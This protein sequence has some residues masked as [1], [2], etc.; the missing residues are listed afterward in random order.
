MKKLFKILL[1]LAIVVAAVAGIYAWASAGK[2]DDKNKLVEVK[3]GS[4]TEKAL[5]VGQIEPRQ[6]FSVKSKISGVVKKCL[7]QVGDHVRPG[8]PLFEIAPA[9]T[10]TD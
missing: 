2:K 5:A 8:D 6:K 1:L 9:P 4:I 10:P 3:K 7:V